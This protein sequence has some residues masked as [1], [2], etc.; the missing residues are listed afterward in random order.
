MFRF[1]L[2]ISVA[3]LTLIA[4]VWLA[5]MAVS[6]RSAPLPLCEATGSTALYDNQLIRVTGA[7]SGNVGGAFALND[8]GCGGEYGVFADVML[9]RQPEYSG[10]VEDLKRLNTADSYAT[11]QVVLTGKFEDLGQTCTA[12]RYRLS[13]ARLQQAGPIRVEIVNQSNSE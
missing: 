6:F 3:V 10:L 2:R 13:G 4:G 5:R 9:E 12:L 7:L 8:L 11:S 1:L